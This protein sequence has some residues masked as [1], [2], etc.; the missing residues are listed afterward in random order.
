MGIC[1][2]GISKDGPRMSKKKM[3]LAHGFV[4][5]CGRLDTEDGKEGHWHLQGIAEDEDKAI[6]MCEDETYFI[7]PVPF[8]TALPI[9]KIDWVGSYFPL[10][11]K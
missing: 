9:Q 2:Y 7:G 10:R 5:V 8:N 4:W 11:Q 1:C 6:L 3:N